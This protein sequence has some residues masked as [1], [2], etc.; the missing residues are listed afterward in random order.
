MRLGKQSLGASG[1]RL[2]SEQRPETGIVG[3]RRIEAGGLN[4]DYI[5]GVQ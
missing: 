2:I 4:I 1:L 3:S 5:N